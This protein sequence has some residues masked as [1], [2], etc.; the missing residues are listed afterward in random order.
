M[1]WAFQSP[2][3]PAGTFAK[4][5]IG[6]GTTNA[7]VFRIGQTY[8]ND[9]WV[10]SRLVFYGAGSSPIG[11]DA[12]DEALSH[13]KASDPKQCLQYRGREDS[14]LSD[15]HAVEFCGETLDG[16]V[17][18]SRVPWK[19][20]KQKLGGYVGRDRDWRECRTFLIGGGSLVHELRREL[21]V[22]PFDK[23]VRFRVQD[24][25]APPDLRTMDLNPVDREALP[26][27]LVA[28]GLS[29]LGLAI[30]EVNTPDEVEALPPMRIRQLPDHEDLYPP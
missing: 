14:L 11:M 23:T 30:P 3:V 6:A 15:Q 5:D 16:I 21:P 17:L 20:L 24:L 18:A 10:K 8:S 29:Q 19:Q 22:Y 28:Y 12:L 2:A 26:F 27:V 9:R 7:S 13:W 1:W 25:E 4:V